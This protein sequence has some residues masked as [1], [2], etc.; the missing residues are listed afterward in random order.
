MFE[1]KL[2]LGFNMQPFF[3]RILNTPLQ[4]WFKMDYGTLCNS[5]IWFD[6]KLE[7]SKKIKINQM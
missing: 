1:I 5:T 2:F 3:W 4:G 6:E 7:K